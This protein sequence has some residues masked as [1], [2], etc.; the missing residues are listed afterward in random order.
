MESKTNNSVGLYRLCLIGTLLIVAMG[1]AL[2]VYEPS[3]D[4]P[5]L[6]YSAQEENRV[7]VAVLQP[8]DL[9]VFANDRVDMVRNRLREGDNPTF[10]LERWSTRTLE[11]IIRQPLQVVRTSDPDWAHHMCVYHIQTERKDK[12]YDRCPEKS[13]T[14]TASADLGNPATNGREGGDI[15]GDGE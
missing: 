9:I 3:N 8:L 15:N 5:A 7:K 14:Q 4:L 10:D 12:P 13:A 2:L 6:S 1:A 11:E